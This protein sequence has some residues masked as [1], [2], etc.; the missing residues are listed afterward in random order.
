[1]CDMGL[2]PEQLTVGLGIPKFYQER[3]D[4]ALDAHPDWKPR[5]EFVVRQVDGHIVQMRRH[6]TANQLIASIVWPRCNV[7][8]S[9]G[10]FESQPTTPQSIRGTPSASRNI[11]NPY[12][13]DTT[14]HT[15]TTLILTFIVVA[16]VDKFIVWCRRVMCVVFSVLCVVCCV[17][18]LNGFADTAANIPNNQKAFSSKQNADRL[19]NTVL[20]CI[21]LAQQ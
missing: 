21:Q 2:S 7:R 1:M 8:G 11:I 16:V 4:D 6:G 15:T 12:G 3:L 18:V 9:A 13:T 20:L 17:F 19:C 14:I 10:I 5:V